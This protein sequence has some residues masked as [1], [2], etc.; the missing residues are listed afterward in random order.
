M[1]LYNYHYHVLLV[2]IGYTGGVFWADMAVIWGS[3]QS[4]KK[5]MDNQKDNMD[6]MHTMDVAK[7]PWYQLFERA[8][9]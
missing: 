9:C 7:N 5:K 6:D 2:L 4:S 8:I 1:E 3:F